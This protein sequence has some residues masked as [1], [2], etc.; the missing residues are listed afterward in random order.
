MTLSA[1][2][3]AAAGLILASILLA[4][5]ATG[6][7]IYAQAEGRIEGQVV[8]GTAGA[9]APSGIPITVHVLQ[10]RTKVGEH[11]VST[12][13]A[14]RFQIEGLPV[15]TGQLYF[16][17]VEYGGASYF[18]ER[19]I[20]VDGPAPQAV[21]IRVFEPVQSDEAIGFDRANMLVTSAAPGALSM[22]EMGA[23]VNGSDRTYVGHRSEDGPAATLRFALPQG[24]TQVTPQAGLPATG[25][26][27]TPDGFFS[28][29]P[30]LPGRHE[31]ALSYQV[32]FEATSFEMTKRL[33]HPAASF[34]LYVPAAGPSVVSPQLQA[35]GTSELGGQ[36]YQIYQA[37]GLAAG[38]EIVIRFS[39]LPA[40]P[41]ARSQQLGLIVVG[42]SAAMLGAA[43]LIALRRRT[44]T[45][46]LAPA[47]PEHEPGLEAHERVELLRALAE[48][49]ERFGVGGIDEDEYRRQRERGKARLVALLEPP[50]GSR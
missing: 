22:M 42:S 47:R 21:Q 48:L 40:T 36:R 50:L 10:D 13:P 39:G 4:F 49:D 35:G 33:E 15:G 41:K 6:S 1:V 23:V 29:F 34:T 7:R 43:A 5:D 45:P 32:P 8:N 31:L 3:R 14:G 25:L 17:I 46:T 19:P 16:P 44:S 2:G 26:V 11:V 27:G 12:D 30:V 37:H 18:P 24:A 28:T 38:S 20:V 9:P